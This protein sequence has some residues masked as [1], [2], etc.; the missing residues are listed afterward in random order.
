MSDQQGINFII[1][2]EDLVLA[3]AEDECTARLLAAVRGSRDVLCAICLTLYPLHCRYL[4]AWFTR[5]NVPNFS[6]FVSLRAKGAMHGRTTPCQNPTRP[7]TLRTALA[8]T[9]VN[10]CALLK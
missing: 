1:L 3:G 4:V 8:P 2:I 9:K 10:A 7:S 6:A 5:A